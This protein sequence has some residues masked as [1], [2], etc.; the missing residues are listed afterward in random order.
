MSDIIIIYLHY[1]RFNGMISTVND[2][3]KGGIYSWE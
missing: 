1:N 3:F 2:I